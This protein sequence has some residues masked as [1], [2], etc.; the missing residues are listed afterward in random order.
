M[1]RLSDLAELS[2]ADRT[3]ALQA[4]QA[5]HASEALDFSE[6]ARL[7]A[8]RHRA[9]AALERPERRRAWLLAPAALAV[10]LLIAVLPARLAVNTAPVA[11]VAV[12]ANDLVALEWAADEAGPDFYRDLEFYQWLSQQRELERHPEPNA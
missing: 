2:D 11:P 1:K 12:N 5:L 7:A 9:L 3:F 8:A 4:R 10:A 6:S